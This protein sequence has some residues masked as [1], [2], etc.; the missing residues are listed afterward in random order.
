MLPATSGRRCGEAVVA[1]IG[2]GLVVKIARRSLVD[3]GRRADLG[4]APSNTA[5]ELLAAALPARV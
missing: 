3:R 4:C 5:T 2:D 1:V